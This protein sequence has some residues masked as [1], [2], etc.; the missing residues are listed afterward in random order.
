MNAGAKA[1]LRP[2]RARVLEELAS[3][4]SAA[5]VA[6]RL[7]VARQKVAYHLKELEKDGLVEVVEERK[8]GNCVERIVKAT[9][10]ADLVSAEALG[11]LAGG[12]EGV[13][14]RFSAAYLVAIAAQ[15]AREVA[16]LRREAD[17]ANK[18]LATLTLQTEI[19]FAGAKER[20]AFAE[21]LTKAIAAL[22]AKYHDESAPR[23]R[24]Y[25]VAAL[26]HPK[27][28]SPEGAK[29]NERREADT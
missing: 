21:E 9:A 8:V 15:S 24:T 27:P 20:A 6:R 23:G 4:A 25:R 11:A 28:A 2:L 14:D 19:R 16:M 5:A 13:Q 18:K 10:R 29:P 1:L 3:P 7:S 22:A 26:A 17:E 12:A